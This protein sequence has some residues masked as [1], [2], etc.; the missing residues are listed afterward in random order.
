VT[1]GIVSGIRSEGIQF[2]API[3]PGSS[4]GPIVDHRGAVVG[5]VQASLV[6]RGTQSLNF[7]IPARQVC[8]SLRVC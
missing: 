6:G 2:T 1:G 4:G 7:A 5:V 8:S 3:S